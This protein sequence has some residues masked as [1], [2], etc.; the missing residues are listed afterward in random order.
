MRIAAPLAAL[1]LPATIA[2]QA[3]PYVA[4]DDPRLA[5]FEHLIVVG[6][7]VDPSPMIRPFRRADAVRVL[8]SAHA[9]PDT[10]DTALVT[11]L[12]EAWRPDSGEATWSLLARAGAQG[13]TAGRRDPLHPAGAGGVQPYL[14]VGITG[15]WGNLLAVS[16]PAIDRR[17]LDDPDWPGRK[18]LELTGR[19]VDA[20]LSG[21]FR[22]LRLF[23]GQMD[24]NWGP[25]GLPGIGVSDYGYSRPEIGIELGNDRFRLRAQAASLSDATDSLGQVVHRYFFAHR[26]DA[27]LHPRVTLGLWEMVVLA[28]AD[29]NFDGRYR[30][31]V[32]LLQ[33]ANQ[34]G[35]GDEGNVLLGVDLSWRVGRRVTLQGQF[36][37]DDF[38]YQQRSGPTRVPDRYAFTV[39]ATGPLAHRL[40]WRAM[41]TQASSLAFRASNPFENLTD[42]GIGIGRNFA[43]N[44]QLTVSG[45]AVVARHWLVAPELTLLRQGDATLSDPF[46]Q[47]T[48]RGSTPALFIGTVERTFRAALGVSGQQGRLAVRGN[49][50]LHLVDNAD[51]IAGRSR[52]RF[53]GQVSATV[54]LGAQGQF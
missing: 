6:D 36:A 14:E 42:A 22:W 2:A 11:A 45:S 15:R 52:T 50:G 25:V 40:G 39:A 44:D 3:S 1:L 37:L 46:P 7:V 12:R 33:L 31:P 18:N 8:D 48:A 28:G 29:R 49:M 51:H 54:A 20:Y 43:G 16:R 17:L 35:L 24:R 19:Q 27:R 38:H 9:D 30:N 47:G 53:I 26:V 41:Y 34:Y 13:Y 4:L 10:R 5:A 21:Q 23:Y 32:A